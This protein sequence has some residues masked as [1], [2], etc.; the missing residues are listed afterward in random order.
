MEREDTFHALCRCPIAQCLWRDMEKSWRM[1]KL[2]V[3]RNTGAEWLL[4]LLDQ[5][6]PEERLPVLMT[7][8]RSWHV[9]NELTHGKK[10]PPV[11]ASTRFLSSYIETLLC[12]KQ[13]PSADI[14]KGKMVISHQGKPITNQDEN[15][16]TNELEE[17]WIQ[18]PRGWTKLNMDG[19]FN[20]ENHTGGAGMILHGEG[21][22]VIFS[23]CRYLRSCSSALEAELAACMEGIA[24]AR[25]WSVLPMIIETDCL[26]AAR[27]IIQDGMN[28]SPCATM[29][30]QIQRTLEEV[31]EHVM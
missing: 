25:A 23:S 18:P 10:A 9:H 6:M 21:G 30:T 27:M 12:L 20:T 3:V 8:W 11:E 2:E 26:T 14:A 31:G 5:C 24:I 16:N 13:Y 17:R 1:P 7:L 22:Q 15:R 28:R 4:H 29:V 19:A